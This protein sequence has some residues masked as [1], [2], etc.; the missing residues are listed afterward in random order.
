MTSLA[1]LGLDKNT[2]AE[3]TLCSVELLLNKLATFA[4]AVLLYQ[5]LMKKKKKA[6]RDRRMI[7]PT[8]HNSVQHNTML[9]LFC[10]KITWHPRTSTARREILPFG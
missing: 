9:S 1:L 3:R 7:L 4:I 8:K 10:L 6:R 5:M 2:V